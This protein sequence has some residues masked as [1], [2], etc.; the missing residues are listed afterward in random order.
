MK[1]TQCAF[2]WFYAKENNRT[3][4]LL[5]HRADALFGTPGGKLEA[6]E[7]VING[8]KREL[9]EEINYV[10]RTDIRSLGIF[11]NPRYTIF[12]YYTQ[13]TLQDLKNIQQNFHLAEMGDETFGISIVDITDESVRNRILNYP[14][15][16]TG[17]EELLTLLRHCN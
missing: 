12:S 4:L 17:K 9:I 6:D 10:T 14:F 11:E 16:G 2:L 8:L 5:Q 13:T 15:A 7:T 3:Y 1:K